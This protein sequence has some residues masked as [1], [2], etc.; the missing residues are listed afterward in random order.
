MTP[1]PHPE[2]ADTTK[3]RR[4]G[5]HTVLALIAVGVLFA[6]HGIVLYKASA[7]AA[8]PAIVVA[9][10]G[11]AVLVKH[12]GFFRALYSLYRARFRRDESP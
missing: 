2:T 10:L 1:P 5:T 4:L 8:V 9:S 7:H 12:L 6:A 3:A 11:I